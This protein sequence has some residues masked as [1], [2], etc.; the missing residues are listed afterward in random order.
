MNS[1]K[2]RKL[3]EQYAEKHQFQ[4]EVNQLMKIL[5]ES[6]YRFNFINK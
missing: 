5:I 1:V 6:L 2:E 4:T 3:L